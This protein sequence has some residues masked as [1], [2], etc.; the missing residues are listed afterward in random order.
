MRKQQ[1]E[2]VTAIF[3]SNYLNDASAVTTPTKAPAPLRVQRHIPV[4]PMPIRFSGFCH[5]SGAPN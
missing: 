1:P 5:H 4:M 3:P 2:I